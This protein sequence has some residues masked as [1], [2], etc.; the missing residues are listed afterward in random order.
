MELNLLF[1][2]LSTFFFNVPFGFVRYGF[3]KFSIMW[4]VFIH[5]PIPFVILFRHSFGL[6]FQLYTYPVM[7]SAFFLGQFA[8]KKIRIRR[9]LKRSV[10]K[11]IVIEDIK[12]DQ[13]W[14]WSF[15]IV[16]K[17]VL[18]FLFDFFSFFFKSWFFKQC[19]HVTFVCFNTWLIKRVYIKNV[20]TNTTSNF[21]E[22]Y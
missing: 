21:K 22:V 11:R 2:A 13:L 17:L 5:L 8:G 15:F 18:Q 10:V 9:N 19:K 1:A 6:G 14:S 4:F 16:L 12:K 3:K 7:V 20:T